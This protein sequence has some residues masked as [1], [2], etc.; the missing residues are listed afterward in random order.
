MKDLITAA[1]APC[2]KEFPYYEDGTVFNLLELPKAEDYHGVIL[3]ILY[4]RVRLQSTI[5]D[6]FTILC[7]RGMLDATACLREPIDWP[8]SSHPKRVCINL[9]NCFDSV[10][11][12]SGQ[13]KPFDYWTWTEAPVAWLAIMIAR[14]CVDPN[15]IIAEIETTRMLGYFHREKFELLKQGREPLVWTCD[16]MMASGVSPAYF[17]WWLPH[18]LRSKVEDVDAFASFLRGKMKLFNR[19]EELFNEWYQVSDAELCTEAGQQIFLR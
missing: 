15:I 1:S 18:G 11:K 12:E 7:L 6:I 19:I 9:L 10:I 3:K 14:A 2:V 16:P 5:W 8:S 17:G 4:Y 13:Q